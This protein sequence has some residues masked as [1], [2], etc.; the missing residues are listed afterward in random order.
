MNEKKKVKNYFFELILLIISFLI[1]FYRS[2]K[3]FLFSKNGRKK[4]LFNDFL[5]FVFRK[6][7]KY[8]WNNPSIYKLFCL[9]GNIINYILKK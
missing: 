1:A 3:L 6:W 4:N 8:F 7:P 5:D 2:I 9:P